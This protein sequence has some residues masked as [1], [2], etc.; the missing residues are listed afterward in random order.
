MASYRARK[1]PKTQLSHWFDIKA[2]CDGEEL[3]NMPRFTRLAATRTW[4]VML[5][6]RAFAGRGGEAAE[7]VRVV[8]FADH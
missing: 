3:L 7:R 5:I 1:S 6:T 4:R 8:I 2:L